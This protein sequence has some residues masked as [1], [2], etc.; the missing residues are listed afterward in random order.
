MAVA[1]L[2]NENESFDTESSRFVKSPIYHGLEIAR[3]NN[4]RWL[5]IARGSQLR[6]Y[7]T[8]P[9]VGVGRRG[10]T[11]TYFGLDLALLDDEHAGYLELAF[12]ARALTPGGSADEILVSSR[13]YTRVSLSDGGPGRP[14]SA[15]RWA[16]RVT[17]SITRWPRASSPRSRRSCSTGHSSGPELTPAWPS[18]TT[19]RP[20]ITRTA[21]TRP[22]ATSAPRSSRGGT[23]WPSRSP[24]PPHRSSSTKAGQLHNDASIVAGRDGGRARLHPEVAALFGERHL[25]AV[26]LR[27]RRPTSKSQVERTIDYLE[28]SFLPLRTFGS[29][30]DLQAQHDAWAAEVAHRRILRRTGFRAAERWAA[31][32]RYLHP[33][34]AVLPDVA[35][36]LEARA[37]KDAFVRVL[38]AGVQT[39]I[40]LRPTGTS[41]NLGGR[42][43][44]RRGRHRG[45]RRPPHARRVVGAGD[46]TQSFVEGACSRRGKQVYVRKA[47]PLANLDQPADDRR[48]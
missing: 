30:A 34:P 39:C 2:L 26:V 16:R 25:A 13:D 43:L 23:V 46:E 48:T 27:P 47:D 18:S 42:R 14:G 19:S 12:G 11:Q 44:S 24:D 7:P 35:L 36:R 21:G 32:R 5:V 3:R 17:V 15:C 38:C 28:T 45:A 37:G 8:S 29:L 22:S 1:I 31:E 10:A 4:V 6:L 9:D 41:V 20:S 40:E 33:L